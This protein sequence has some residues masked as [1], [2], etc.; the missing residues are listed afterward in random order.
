VS[1]VFITL[2]GCNVCAMVCQGFWVAPGQAFN[3]ELGPDECVT[4]SAV[5]STPNGDFC[6]DGDGNGNPVGQTRDICYRSCLPGIVGM[7]TTQISC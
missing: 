6:L 4:V 7:S 2:G 1:Q 5:A 3:T